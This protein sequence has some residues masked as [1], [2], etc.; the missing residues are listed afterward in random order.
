MHHRHG[1]RH[2]EGRIHDQGA[3]RRQRG[4]HADLREDHLGQDDHPGGL[5]SH[6][7]PGVEAEDPGQGGLPP[8]RSSSADPDLRGQAVVRGRAVCKQLQAQR[9]QHPEG[10]HGAPLSSSSRRGQEGSSRSLGGH[11]PQVHRSAWG[12]GHI[13]HNSYT[14]IQVDT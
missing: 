4:C 10:V 11:H 5:A 1:P 14:Y 13:E 7:H 2:G 12:E 3:L 6:H 9:L 8:Q